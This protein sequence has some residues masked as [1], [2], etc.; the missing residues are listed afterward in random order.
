[1]A[2]R[3]EMPALAIVH[4]SAGGDSKSPAK[5]T[6]TA[7][8]RSVDARPQQPAQVHSDAEG[9]AV[10]PQ[11]NAAAEVEFEI[12]VADGFIVDAGVEAVVA[13]QIRTARCN[14]GRGETSAVR[15]AAA[16]TALGRRTAAEH[17]ADDRLI[18]PGCD[19]VGRSGKAEL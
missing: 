2:A 14:A 7:A 5:N 15:G 18:S 9:I 1:M 16:G 10:E 17:A 6:E 4:E 3:A 11:R 19:V 12:Q 8:E 13:H